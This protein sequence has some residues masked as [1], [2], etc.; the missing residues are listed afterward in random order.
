MLELDLKYNEL[1]KQSIIFDEYEVL[2]IFFFGEE[3]IDVTTL[4]G[5]GLV[6]FGFS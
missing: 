3:H 6:N 2:T 1:V 4:A 5:F